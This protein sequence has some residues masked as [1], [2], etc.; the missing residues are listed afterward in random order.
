MTVNNGF[1]IKNDR[2]SLTVP[3]EYILRGWLA[4]RA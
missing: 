3:D 1:L 2:F 4:E